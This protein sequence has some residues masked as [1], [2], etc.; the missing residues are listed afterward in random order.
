MQNYFAQTIKNNIEALGR[1]NNDLEAFL[2]AHPLPENA[3]YALNLAL[4]EMLTNI[5]KYGYDDRSEHLIA[6]RI[7]IDQAH[8][9]LTLE[10][11]GHPFN[12]LTVAEPERQ[13]VL[14][15]RPIGGLGIFLVRSLVDKMTYQRRAGKNILAITIKRQPLP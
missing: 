4:E 12:P 2:K 10:D 7:D 11:D 15:H 14:H 6:V 8:V 1:L 5:I 13:H 9:R 3:H